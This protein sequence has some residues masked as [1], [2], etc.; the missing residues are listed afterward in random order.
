MFL[1]LIRKLDDLPLDVIGRAIA[2]CE[3]DSFIELVE[4]ARP[5]K[6]SGKG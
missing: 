4:T 2:A 5:A 6:R 1:D 3:V